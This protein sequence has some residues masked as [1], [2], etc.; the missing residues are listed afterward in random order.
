VAFQDEEVQTLTCL[1]LTLCQ[2]RVYLALARSGMSTAKTISKVSKVTREDIYRI[3]P[4]LQ[5]LGLVENIS[6]MDQ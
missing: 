6:N 2:A 4:T 5:K 3:M 1:G